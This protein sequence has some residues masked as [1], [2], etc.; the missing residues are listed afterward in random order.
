[1]EL[2]RATSVFSDYSW[3][4]LCD[5]KIWKE[6]EQLPWT[7]LEDCKLVQDV[8]RKTLLHCSSK[9]HK[10]GVTCFCAE[11]D[12]QRQPV[13]LTA[14]RHVNLF[15]GNWRVVLHGEQDE[16]STASILRPKRPAALQ[17]RWRA[18]GPA[19]LHATRPPARP[20]I[21]LLTDTLLPDDKKSMRRK[22]LPSN[23]RGAADDIS[24]V[25]RHRWNP[26]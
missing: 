21:V 5:A 19:C 16:Q 7:S 6:R 11:T 10:H 13:T 24:T 25:V 20:V 4:R 14:E 26:D 15:L 9:R 12:W 22:L 3:R 8:C 17:C 18:R 2:W 1:M 23:E